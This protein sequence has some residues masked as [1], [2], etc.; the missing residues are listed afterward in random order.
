LTVRLDRTLKAKLGAIARSTKRSESDLAAEAI[1]AFLALNEWQID[2]IE[3][4]IADLDSGRAVSEQQ[5]EALYEGLL[6]AR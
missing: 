2:E 6:R 4:G 5:A 1:G 3:S